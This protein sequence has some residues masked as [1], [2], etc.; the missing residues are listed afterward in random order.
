[1][2]ANFG[3]GGRFEILRGHHQA[4]VDF[5]GI[6][7][8]DDVGMGKARL[9]AD[10]PQET[11]RQFWIAG[12]DYGQGSERFDFACGAV[13]NL[14]SNA[15]LRFVNNTQALIVT[16]HLV[17]CKTHCCPLGLGSLGLDAARSNRIIPIEFY[18]AVKVPSISR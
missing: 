13:S 4:A 1:D 17:D 14:V 3:D 18:D 16:D 6:V 8:L 11:L 5:E 10:L 9:D 12:G 2:T 15:C 7:K